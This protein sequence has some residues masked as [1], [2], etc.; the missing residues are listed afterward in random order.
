MKL[1]TS[2][3]HV[4]QK[5]IKEKTSQEN[6]GMMNMGTLTPDEKTHVVNSVTKLLIQINEAQEQLEELASQYGYG[7][8]PDQEK[9]KKFV[10]DVFARCDFFG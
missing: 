4:P 8:A 3:D 7:K 6:R 1:P 2:R 9:V 5:T 10:H